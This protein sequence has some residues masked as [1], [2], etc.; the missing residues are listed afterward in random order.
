MRQ[1]SE[2]F[3][4]RLAADSTTLCTCLRFTR[5]DGQVFGATDH[6]LP[7]LFDGVRYEPAA[8][9]DAVTF[10]TSAGLA[11]GRAAANGVL[12]LAFISE[13][14]LE[15]GLWDGCWVD[16]WRVD[17]RAPEHRVV[18]WS[19][20][21]SEIIRQGE[22][23][24]AELVSLKAD[25]ERPIGRVYGRACDADVGDARCSVDLAAPGFRGEGA[26]G[27]LSGPKS[28]L[29]SGAEEFDGGWFTGGV[30]NWTSGANSGTTGRV[31]RHA[32]AQ[33]ELAVAPRFA[34]EV[35]DAFVLITGCDKS[36]ATCGAKFANR[37][38]FRGFPHMPGVDAVLAGPASDRVNDGGKR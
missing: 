29:V 32:G 7:M 31:R 38:N 37:I 19:G 1:I 21:L 3:V 17:W 33:I 2:A 12:S 14:D 10:Q 16:V 27:S 28:F 22:A 13:S 9:I 35:D 24:A 26:V 5:G 6:D 15:A 23:F 18:I 20:R 4:A 30:L 11:P 36:F 34:I 25:L 8:G